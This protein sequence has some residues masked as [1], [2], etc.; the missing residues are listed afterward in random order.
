MASVYHETTNDDITIDDEE[1]DELSA[2]EYDEVQV[3]RLQ[4]WPKNI[5]IVL[6]VCGFL[7][8]CLGELL[9]LKNNRK[10]HY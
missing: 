5:G 6:I 3:P 1:I 8:V 4:V 10:F 2:Q 9:R 7:T